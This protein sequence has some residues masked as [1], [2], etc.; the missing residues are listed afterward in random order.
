MVDL[1][2]RY[3]KNLFQI[4]KFDY[5]CCRS[6]VG[7]WIEMPFRKGLG[8][9]GH[10]VSVWERGLKHDLRVH[11]AGALCVVPVWEREQKHRCCAK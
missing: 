2:E 10:V 4:W 6:R 11:Q 7:T 3:I 1:D 8:S 5:I 9:S